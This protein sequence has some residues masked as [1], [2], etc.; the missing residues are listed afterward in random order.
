MVSRFFLS[1]GLCFHFVLKMFVWDLF[2]CLIYLSIGRHFLKCFYVHFQLVSICT[3]LTHFLIGIIFDCT[4]Y[5]H[6]F[7]FRQK[8]EEHFVLYSFTPL[9]MIDKKGE[10]N[11]RLYACFVCMFC[12]SRNIVCF[13][14]VCCLLVLR[15]F[16]FWYQELVK[17]IIS[18]VL[19]LVSRACFENLF[20]LFNWYQEHV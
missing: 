15:A 5:W 19:Q 10:K 16:Y 1:I 13:L 9:L 12:L 8:G 14:L 18:F 20:V 7:C 11:L 6:C 17:G 2:Q 4:P 3:S